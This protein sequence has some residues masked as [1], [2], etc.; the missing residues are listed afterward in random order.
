MDPKVLS[1]IPKQ[2]RQQLKEK[3][4]HREEN[5]QVVGKGKR[6]EVQVKQVER[7]HRCTL[8]VIK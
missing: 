7:I 3:Q 8:S 5:K 1:E 4:A 2:S 6:V